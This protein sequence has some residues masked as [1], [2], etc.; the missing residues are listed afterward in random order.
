M[1]ETSQSLFTGLTALWFDGVV[2]VWILLGC[3]RGWKNG[4]SGEVCAVSKWV[5]MVV[6]GALLYRPLAGFIGMAGCFPNSWDCRLGYLAPCIV[7]WIGAAKVTPQISD[8]LN[9]LSIGDRLD[10]VWGLVLGLVRYLCI[11]LVF[12]SLFNAAEP[13]DADIGEMDEANKAMGNV[14]FNPLKLEREALQNSLTGRFL[15]QRAKFIIIDPHPGN[16]TVDA[17]KDLKARKQSVIDDIT[18]PSTNK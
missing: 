14:R 1:N 4:F 3:Y 13:T 6:A 5:L 16:I 12:F 9:K 10:N 15:N 11:F 17:Y 2:L 18:G 8:V 7:I